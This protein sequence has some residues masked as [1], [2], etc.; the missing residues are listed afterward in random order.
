MELMLGGKN[1]LYL[2]ENQ[3]PAASWAIHD[4]YQA[5]RHPSLIS[6]LLHDLD[7]IAPQGAPFSTAGRFGAGR[8]AAP[9]QQRAN[10]PLELLAAALG[11]DQINSK[12]K[13]APSQCTS[14]SPSAMRSYMRYALQSAM[15]SPASLSV[16]LRCCFLVADGC[17]Q[18][19]TQRAGCRHRPGCEGPRAAG[20]PWPFELVP[21]FLGAT[22]TNRVAKAG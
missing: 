5:C 6:T 2:S 22:T 13:L 15:P 12:F 10:K 18:R 4:V 19:D 11:A 16:L 1:L 7:W 14:T 17:I 9:A 20:L 8:H 21:D 3:A